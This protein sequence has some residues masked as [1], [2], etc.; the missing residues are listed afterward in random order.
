MDCWDFV[1]ISLIPKIL[2]LDNGM[3]GFCFN[4]EKSNFIR[5]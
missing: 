3:R 1:M 2:D 5:K 4:E